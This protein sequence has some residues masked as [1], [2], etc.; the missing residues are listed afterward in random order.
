MICEKC[1][2]EIE[3]EAL[4]CKYCGNKVEMRAENIPQQN[5]NMKPRNPSM[6]QQNPN[7][8]PQNP[9]RNKNGKGL[10]IALIV[11]GCAVV[12]AIII[13]CLVYFSA[14]SKGG[15]V[16]AV[17]GNEESYDDYDDVKPSDKDQDDDIEMDDLDTDAPDVDDVSYEDWGMAY[18]DYIENVWAPVY[19]A[20]DETQYLYEILYLDD[21]Y[22][23]EILIDGMSEAE[24][25]TLLYYSDG[26]VYAETL[27]GTLFSYIEDEGLLLNYGGKMGCY[28][29][30]VYKLE[31]GLFY[32]L[33]SGSYEEKCDSNGTP[34]SL[35]DPNYTEPDDYS[36]YDLYLAN[37][38]EFYTFY[39]DDEEV[40]CEEYME[41][42]EYWYDETEAINGDVDYTYDEIVSFLLE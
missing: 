34:L 5:P 25:N 37:D 24:G 16:T 10:L 22:I 11:G 7:V 20:D 40:S 14:G 39:W 17:L 26:E 18:I 1:G 2:K 32:E 30:T 12:A 36:A 13:V 3:S 38:E 29:D 8:Q 27:R 9:N 23:P 21:D 6:P 31:D 42:L 28:F 19:A 4:F 35:S 41:N 15:H 33:G